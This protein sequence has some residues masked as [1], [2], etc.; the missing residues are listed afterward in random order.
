MN[1]NFR[2]IEIH[3]R[4]L[5]SGRHSSSR[6]TLPPGVTT[7]S[8]GQVFWVTGPDIDTTV[9]SD[10]LL[11]YR[12]ES[13]GGSV[14]AVGSPPTWVVDVQWR[15]G[16]TDNRAQASAEAMDLTDTTATVASGDVYYLYCA[17]GALVD[18]DLRLLVGA[19]ARREIANALVQ[20]IAVRSWGEHLQ[21][22][23]W[24]HFF[25]PENADG[26]NSQLGVLVESF[27][28]NSPMEDWLRWSQENCWALNRPELQQVRDYFSNPEVRM[29][30]FEIGLPES[31]TDVEMEVIAQTWSE[32]C[33]HKIFGANIDYREAE[34]SCDVKGHKALGPMKING[35]F[36]SEIV[37]AT[38][39]VEASRRIAWLSSTFSDNAGMVRFDEAIDVSIKVETH[40]SPSALDPYGGA[41]TGILGVNRDILGVGMGA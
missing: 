8:V 18:E 7:V 1:T 16:V 33:K 3:D 14:T 38:R 19:W 2:R 13:I 20:K 4:K 28:L 39:E 32:H 25:A 36:K 22:E 34:N 6:W 17:D 10:P 15:P 23:V 24:E 40:N 29:R 35:L 26:V 37:R 11:Q 31:P 12:I 30:R 41:L 9:L 5:S 21:H 27:P